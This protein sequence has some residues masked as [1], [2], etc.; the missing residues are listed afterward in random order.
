VEGPGSV[1]GGKGSS[2]QISPTSSVNVCDGLFSA[3]KGA[4]FVVDLDLFKVLVGRQGWPEES[5][6]D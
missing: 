3:D 2:C 1:K 6:L 5:S 4:V